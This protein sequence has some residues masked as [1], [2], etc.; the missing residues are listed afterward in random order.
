MSWRTLVLTA[1]LLGTLPRNQRLRV[2]V[3]DRD[4][5]VRNGIAAAL[6]R[7]GHRV[8]ARCADAEAALAAVERHR[9]DICLIGL[10]LPGGG[11]TT[12]RAI[13]ARRNKP[14]IIILASTARERD[15][16]AGLRAGADA[17]VVKD[18]DASTLPEHVAAVA[19][20]EA[21]LPVGMTARLIDE[22]RSLARTPVEPHLQHTNPAG[23]LAPASPRKRGSS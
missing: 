19:A 1:L 14:R 13:S 23:A 8:V 15:V 12:T 17:F 20:G 18:V 9:I 21:V 16:F 5:A 2:L 4:E 11:V 7:V 22:F 6:E 3:A 10:D